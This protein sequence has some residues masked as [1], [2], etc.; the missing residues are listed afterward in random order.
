MSNLCNGFTGNISVATSI[1]ST[2]DPFYQGVSNNEL[3]VYIEDGDPPGLLVTPAIASVREGGRTAYQVSLA[4]PPT[5]AVTMS[6]AITWAEGFP[7]GVVL[8]PSTVIFLPG[9]ALIWKTIEVTLPVDNTYVGSSVAVVHHTVASVD[10]LYDSSRSTGPG[11]A[12]LHLDVVDETGAAGLC[13]GLCDELTKFD[14]V[15]VSARN[16]PAGERVT[17]LPDASNGGVVTTFYEAR[18]SSDPVSMKYFFKVWPF[19]LP[20]NMPLKPA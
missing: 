1:T 8:T 5:A 11:T 13:L 12:K 7:Q 20:F 16:S 6:T 19:N 14:V 3:I 15:L 9:E 18:S 2:S 10:P 17:S 4:T